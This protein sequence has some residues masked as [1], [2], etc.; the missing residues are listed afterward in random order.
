MKIDHN[1]TPSNDDSD[2]GTDEEI[3]QKTVVAVKR[4]SKTTNGRTKYDKINACLYCGKGYIKV[5]RHLKQ[6]HKDEFD[7]LQ[8]LS[9][10]KSEEEKKKK[11]NTT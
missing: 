9:Y 6:V 4:C 8:I 11:D 1:A 3:T 10:S 5:W 2:S 7:V